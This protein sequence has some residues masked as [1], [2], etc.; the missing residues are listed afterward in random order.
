M[1]AAIVMRDESSVRRTT[2]PGCKHASCVLE[3]HAVVPHSVV[4]VAVPTTTV[5]VVSITPN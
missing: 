1:S 2:V 5:G 4:P 3:V